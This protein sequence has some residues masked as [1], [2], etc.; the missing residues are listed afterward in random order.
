MAFSFSAE[1]EGSQFKFSN[2]KEESNF[3]DK[4]L[5]DDVNCWIASIS[6]VEILKAL[7]ENN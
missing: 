5:Y 6:G 3:S 7:R 2:D 1:F 4:L